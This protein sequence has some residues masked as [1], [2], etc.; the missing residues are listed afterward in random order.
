MDTKKKIVILVS[1]I[2]GAVFLYF[3]FSGMS[4]KRAAEEKAQAIENAIVQDE[5]TASSNGLDNIEE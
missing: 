4:Q 1:I 5:A 2:I 3:G